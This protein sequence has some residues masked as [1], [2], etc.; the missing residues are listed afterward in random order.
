M[1]RIRWLERRS[2]LMHIAERRRGDAR[3]LLRNK[4]Y[5]GAVYLGGYV[6]ECMLKAAICQW[7]GEERLPERYMTHDLNWLLQQA[8]LVVE[9]YISKHWQDVAIWDV[10]ARYS[11]QVISAQSARQFIDAMEVIRRWLLEVIQQRERR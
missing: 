5:D 11:S 2:V 4:R 6:V 10:T 1:D 3:V 9:P 7:I 8:A